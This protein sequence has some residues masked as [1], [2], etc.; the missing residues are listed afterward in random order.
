M[1]EYVDTAK[2]RYYF[3]DLPLESIHRFAFQAAEAANCAGVEG[4]FWEMHDLLFANRRALATA[5][6]RAYAEQLGLDVDR[7]DSCLEGGEFAASIRSGMALATRLG[8]RSA[9]NFWLGFVDSEDPDKARVV[10]NLRGAQPF[11]AF[12]AHLD[13]LYAEAGASR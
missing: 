7:F 8:V 11:D 5:N 1:K 9:P 3:V 10:R 13:S 12:K 4:K 6:L 2:V